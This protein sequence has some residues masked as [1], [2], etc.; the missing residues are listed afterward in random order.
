MDWSPG[1]QDALDR[2]RGWL[3]DAREQ[4]VFRLFGYA[5]SGKTTLAKHLAEGAGRVAFAAFTGKAAL[6]LRRKGCPAST[7]HSLIYQPKEKSAAHLKRLER[8]LAALRE[9][10][11][12]PVADIAKLQDEVARERQNLKRPSF[13]LKLDSELRA[14]DLLVLD[15]VSM[16]GAQIGGDLC[17]FGV[18]ILA[19]GDP[20][21]LP[22]VMDGGFF[23]NKKPDVMLEEIHRQAADSPIIKMAT[24]VRR[25]GALSAGMRFGDE[26]VVVAKSE[27]PFATMV[28][29]DQVLVGKNETRRC[30]NDRYRREILGFTS[31]LPVAG[32][33][34]VCLRN[35][36]EL[37]LLNGGLWSVE[38]SM[39][40]GDEVAMELKDPDSGVSVAVNAHTAY[41]RGTEKDL[42]HG[43]WRD[44]EAFDFGYALTVHKFQGSEAPNILLVD[45]SSCF[46]QNAY[47][48]LYTGITRAS[49]RLTVMK[50]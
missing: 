6:V 13:N 47:R 21:Q 20:A 14:C 9:K 10:P 27:V 31:E 7:I 4:Q 12:T 44:A 1:Q 33:K 24:I 35:N 46:Q 28:N 29:F 2:V 34:V 45:E 38:S 41:F 15:E 39:D 3:G 18:P 42:P 36:S 11:E 25:G 30:F 48:W 49:E 26:A 50:T 16:V 40:L 22:P 37:G 19:L 43:S 23:T 17:S 5:G 8:E 32:D